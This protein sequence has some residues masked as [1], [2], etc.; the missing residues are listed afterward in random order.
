MLHR[1]FLRASRGVGSLPHISSPTQEDLGYA[2]KS[3]KR[4]RSSKQI[5]PCAGRVP[6]HGAPESSE[7]QPAIPELRQRD[8]LSFA[9]QITKGMN[10]LADMKVSTLVDIAY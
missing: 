6:D 3:L 8:I 1:N 10:Y 7:Q 9:F 4:E 2:K 5:D